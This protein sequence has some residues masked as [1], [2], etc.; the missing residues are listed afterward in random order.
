MY[1]KCQ[2]KKAW[3]P[4]CHIE[5]QRIYDAKIVCILYTSNLEDDEHVYEISD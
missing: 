2:P 1:K 5:E 4:I 3:E